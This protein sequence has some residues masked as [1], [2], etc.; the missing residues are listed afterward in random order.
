MDADVEILYSGKD[1]D[2][3]WSIDSNGLLTIS[4]VGDWGSE[5]GVMPKWSN[6]N[7]KIISNHNLIFNSKTL[8]SA[9]FVTFC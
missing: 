7:D 5:D 3:N 2:L 9:N 1:G 6:Y 4:G 8:Q